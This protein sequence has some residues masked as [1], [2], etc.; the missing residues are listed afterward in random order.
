MTR[1]AGATTRT[2]SDPPFE[3]TTCDC[4]RDVENCRYQPGYLITRDLAR[5]AGHLGITVAELGQRYLWAS[6]G[7]LVGSARGVRRIGTITP[8]MKDGRCVFLQEGDRCAIHAVSPFGC[9]YFDMHMQPSEHRPRS[10]W[11]IA[12]VAASPLYRIIRASLRPATWWKGQPV[13]EETLK[14]WRT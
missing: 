13:N 9:A 14:G 5:I 3:R 12:V 8:R 4:A 1:E 2:P 11:G 10:A 7:A 6:P